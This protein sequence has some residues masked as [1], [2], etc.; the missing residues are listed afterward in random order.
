MVNKKL[1]WMVGLDNRTID[2]GNHAIEEN[3]HFSLLIFLDGGVV[4]YWGIVQHWT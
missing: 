1:R 2:V 4:G 3:N